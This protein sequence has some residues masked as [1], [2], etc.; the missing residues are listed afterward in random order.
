MTKNKIT[1][2]T[3]GL[4]KITSR[5][6]FWTCLVVGSLVAV[7]Y[8]WLHV[9]YMLETVYHSTQDWTEYMWEDVK[10]TESIEDSIAVSRM[11]NFQ[12]GK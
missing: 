7:C 12:T 5:C 4:T 3:K 8:P 11:C 9:T 1:R 10:R 2:E 6:V